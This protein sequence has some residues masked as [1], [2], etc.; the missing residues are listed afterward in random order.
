MDK[1]TPAIVYQRQIETVED[2]LPSGLPGVCAAVAAGSIVALVLGSKDLLAWVNN[3]PIGPFSDY[4]LLVAQAWQ[5]Q[6]VHVRVTGYSD[7]LHKLLS[8]LQAL[9]WRSG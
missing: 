5:D 3:L 2:A 7:T 1:E 6:M 4:L 9:R 8:A